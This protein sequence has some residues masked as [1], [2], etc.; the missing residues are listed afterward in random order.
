VRATFTLA[1]EVYRTIEALA[2][3]KKV[4]ASWVLREAAE[5]YVAGHWPLLESTVSV[6][7]K[8]GP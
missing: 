7:P 5:Q 1:P 4:L 2:R 8:P 6:T 3:Q